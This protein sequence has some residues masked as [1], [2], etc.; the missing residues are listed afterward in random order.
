MSNYILGAG[1]TGLTAGVATK[2]P[3]FEGAEI[4]GGISTSYYVRPGSNKRLAQM[5]KD[6][7][8]YHFDNGGGHWIF[9]ADKNIK[10]FLSKFTYIKSYD[11]R[12]S[13]YFPEKGM[14]V[15]YPAQNNLRYFDRKVTE[16]ILREISG[17]R[18]PALV[19]MKDWMLYNFGPTLCE[20]FFYPFHQ[21]YTADLYKRIVPQEAYKTPVNISMVIKGAKTKVS[22]VGYNATFAYPKEGLDVLIKRIAQKCNIRYRKQ[23]RKFDVKN[24]KIYFSDG[25]SAKYNMLISTLPLNEAMKMAEIRPA[26]KPDPYTSV[27]VLNIGAAKGERCPGDHWLYIPRSKAGFHRVGFYSN[28]DRSFLPVSAQKSNDRVSIYVEKA[29][30]GGRKP[31]RRAIES[32]TVAAVKELQGWGFIKEVE[33]VDAVYVDVAYT[34]SWPY[35][36]WK[37]ESLSELR[38]HGIYQI[39]RY[40][41]WRFQGIADSIRNGLEIKAEIAV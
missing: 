4:A 8:A 12:S 40:G 7:N 35:S 5:P 16:K 23:I 39:G 1:I 36:T 6:G 29:C 37:E 22:P 30:V 31:A 21:L 26:T 9:S 25:G 41:G 17:K 33:A 24:K 19:T 34:W 14:Y 28:V 15:P 11:R 2:W 38:K 10:A 3:I 18:K 13:V 20:L 27:I 32:Y